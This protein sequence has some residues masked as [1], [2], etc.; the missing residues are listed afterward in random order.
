VREYGVPDAIFAHP[1]LAQIYD[2]FTYTFRA[3]GAVITSH[4]TLR[5]RDREEVASSLAATGYQIL[6]VRDA[7]DRPS[8]EHVFITQHKDL[9][10]TGPPPAPAPRVPSWRTTIIRQLAGNGWS[11]RR[12]ATSAASWARAE[13]SSLAKMWAR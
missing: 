8:R 4:S 2:A 12:R 11:R 9:G 7:S 10:R 1:R 6:D 13:M 5:F 3:D